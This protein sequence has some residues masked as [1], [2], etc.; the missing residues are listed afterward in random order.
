MRGRIGSQRVRTAVLKKT[1]GR[2]WYCDKKLTFSGLNGKDDFVVDHI[3]PARV[4]ADDSS[5]LVPCCGSCN[6]SKGRKSVRE[7]LMYLRKLKRYVHPRVQA[8]LGGK[9]VSAK[10]GPGHFSKLAKK[11]WAKKR[12][13]V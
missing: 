13:Q 11:M 1:K 5:N 10:R 8:M 4:G 2:C 7:F 6:H 12:G 3:I 9:A